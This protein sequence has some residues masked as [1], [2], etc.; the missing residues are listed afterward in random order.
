MET[1]DPFKSE[2]DALDF[3]TLCHDALE[4]MGEQ[5]YISTVAAL[6]AEAL[7]RQQDRKSVV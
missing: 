1:I 4:A 5:N 2:L 3:G 6:L 7:C